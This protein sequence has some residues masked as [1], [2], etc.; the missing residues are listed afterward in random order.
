MKAINKIFTTIFTS[1]YPK[2]NKVVGGGSGG[3][4]HI[5]KYPVLCILIHYIQVFG[6]F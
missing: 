1:K 4:I 6:N 5:D 3:K 2:Y